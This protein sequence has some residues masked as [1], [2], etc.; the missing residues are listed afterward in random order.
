M[1]IVYLVR[2][3]DKFSAWLF[4]RLIFYL[5]TIIAKH[6]PSASSIVQTL[7][8]R[9]LPWNSPPMHITARADGQLSQKILAWVC[10]GRFVIHLTPRIHDVEN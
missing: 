5:A 4:H 1:F 7:Q 9:P 3:D 6:R 2:F 8:G 10:Q